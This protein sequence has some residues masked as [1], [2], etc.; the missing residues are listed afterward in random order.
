[1]VKLPII[2]VS[3]YLSKSAGR[4]IVGKGIDVL[5]K[6]VRSSDLTESVERNVPRQH[7]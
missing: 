4:A 7:I 6:P 3:A 5:E 1:M 2:M